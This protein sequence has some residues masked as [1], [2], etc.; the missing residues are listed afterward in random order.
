MKNLIISE[1]ILQSTRMSR[2]E[3]KTEIAVMLFQK[4]KLTLGQA[5]RLAGMSQIQFQHLLASRQIPVRYDV[6]D[7]EHDLETLSELGR[8]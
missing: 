7:F 1:K 3:M 2:E 5:S 4:M 6:E 8:M